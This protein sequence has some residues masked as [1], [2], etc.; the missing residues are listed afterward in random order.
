[1]TTCE[2][3]ACRECDGAYRSETIVG[4]CTAEAES[5]PGVRRDP[6]KMGRAYQCASLT[7]HDPGDAVAPLAAPVSS[8]RVADMLP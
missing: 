6:Q 3:V 2:I 5:L 1:M 8:V 4:S 7:P